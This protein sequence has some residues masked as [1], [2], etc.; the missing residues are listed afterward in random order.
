MGKHWRFSRL[1]HNNGQLEDLIIRNTVICRE[2]LTPELV[3]RLITPE[4]EL[5]HAKHN[6]SE[7]PN[8]PFW[9]IY[10]P[11]GQALSRFI[12]DN[13]DLVKNKNVLDI[14]SGS[15]ASAIASVKAG[16]KIV[17]ANDI[18]E[19]SIRAININATLNNLCVHTIKDNVIGKDIDDIVLLINGKEMSPK[20]DII[21][22]GDMFYDT[23]FSQI[24]FA[25][26]VKL[27]KMNKIILIGDPGRH[28][29]KELT[30]TSEM[31]SFVKVAEYSFQ[32]IDHNGFPTASVYKL[33]KT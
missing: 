5:W 18:D 2:N 27:T 6:D 25:W 33:G 31:G 19:T 10:W 21:L 3:L 9:G 16:A 12:L 1:L 23:E 11:G 8:D 17:L 28:G 32:N 20:W 24:L 7:F 13:K 29:L 15:G 14:G 30:T 22:I 26:L 4:C